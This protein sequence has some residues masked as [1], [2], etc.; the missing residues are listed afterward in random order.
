M[1][2]YIDDDIDDRQIFCEAVKAVDPTIPCIPFESGK[3]A[4]DFLYLNQK[5]PDFVFI[6]INMPGM[7]GYE[8]VRKIRASENLKEVKIVM[9]ST[10]FNSKDIIDFTRQGLMI[11]NKPIA[12]NILVK[13]VKDIIFRIGGGKQ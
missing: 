6:D 4:L 12:F 1:I 11:L 9:H 3:V 7:N 8:C 2:V 13:E 5:L 10:S